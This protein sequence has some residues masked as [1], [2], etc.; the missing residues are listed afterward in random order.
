MLIRDLIE[1][2]TFGIDVGEETGDGIIIGNCDKELK[3]LAICMN[4]TVDVIKKA[5]EWGADLLITH[6]PLYYNAEFEGLMDNY[7]INAKKELVENSHLTIYRYHDHPHL[8]EKDM[9]SFGGAKCLGF[10]GKIEKTQYIAASII[11]CDREYTGLEVAKLIEEKMRIKHPRICGSRDKKTKKI[12][13]CFGASAGVYELLQQ[14]DIGIVLAGETCEWKMGEFARDAALLG[15]SKTL[16]IIGHTGSEIPGMK[17]LYEYLSK[18]TRYETKYFD[19][20]E[21][22]TYTDTI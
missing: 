16:I 20:G 6:E 1:D 10:L 4:A 9:I 14:E 21:V 19:C 17:M 18:D 15:F 13:L 8:N 2:I 3:K 5:K 7:V 12:A 11:N 22:Y